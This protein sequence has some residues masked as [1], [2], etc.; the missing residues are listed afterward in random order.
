MSSA[1]NKGKRWTKEEVELLLSHQMTDRELASHLGRTV[2]SIEDKKHRCNTEKWREAN[3]R[4]YRQ[5]E[6]A[7]NSKK[8]WTR[9]E[10]DIV[11]RNDK[12]DMELSLLLG[13]SV[14]SIQLIR[15]RNG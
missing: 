12:T 5:T 14:K 6:N 10:I 4:Y 13:R 8:R 1:R 9:E 7:K 15:F 11:L 3:R 2:K